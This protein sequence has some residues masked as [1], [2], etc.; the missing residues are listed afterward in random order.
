M[1]TG[2]STP[3]MIE[4]ATAAPGV[5]PYAV[6]DLSIQIQRGF[7]RKMLTILLVQL[8]YSIGLGLIIR[9][10]PV[11]GIR[12]DVPLE[13][14]WLATAFPAQSWSALLLMVCT[15]VG[16]PCLSCVKDKHPWNLIATWLWSTLLAVFLAAADIP[17]AYARAHSMFIIMT[18]LAFG[19]FLLLLLTQLPGLKT[20]E[21]NPGLLSFGVAGLISWVTW[22][23]AAIA[24]KATVPLFM[25]EEFDTGPF[26]S[27]CVVSSIVFAWF[28]YEAFKLSAKMSPDEYMKG[29]IYFY[30]DM[31][32]V[33]MCCALLA[34]LG[35]AGGG[36]GAP[37]TEEEAPER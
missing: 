17:D 32:Y 16:I 28:C 27:S 15:L 31:F 29:V 3:A 9:Y 36:S 13:Q 1:A 8:L 11:G 20:P 23:S 33:C 24:L 2:S 34:C 25:T 6:S 35:S 30:T 10:T 7:R 12:P 26:V 19:V 37:E 18:M 22:L 4:H 5:N 14:S 21:G